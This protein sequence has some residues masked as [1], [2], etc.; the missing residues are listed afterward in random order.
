M[1]ILCLC[2]E[3]YHWKLIPGY[4]SAFRRRNIQ[5]FCIDDTL[6][7]DIHIDKILKLC[8]EQPSWI[9][10]FESALPLLPLGLEHSSIPTVCFHP[11]TYAFTKKRIRWSALFDHVAVFH[12]GYVEIFAA[13]GHPGAFL[14]PHAVNKE[15]FDGPEL[16]REFEVGW[17]GQTTGTNYK[18]RAALLPEL[19]ARFRMNDFS[20]HYSLEEV[21]GVYKRSRIT[22]NI[23]RDD[24]PQDANL[25]VF[26]ALASGALL[27]TQLPTELSELGFK[28]GVGYR[29]RSEIL[30]LVENYLR[31]EPARTKIGS[32]ARA[33][34]LSEHTYDS[35][36]DQLLSHL[37]NAGPGNLAPT[38]SWPATKVSLVSLDFFASHL[39]LGAALRR[40]A[41]I[42]G[43]DLPATWEGAILLARASAKKVIRFS[44]DQ[45][46]KL[47]IKRRGSA[48]R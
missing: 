9:F 40:Y 25:R 29:T 47:S 30:T 20:R 31:D 1:L 33:K 43:R 18:A 4:A 32:A 27:L 41:S 8:P 12:P 46:A 16:P 45:A 5:F 21:A 35:R 24:F 17:V 37:S 42:V 36:V 34:V 19:A 22:V 23:G 28:D 38:R 2:P 3:S 10:H 44:R 7:F 6:P 15:F 13:A 48:S 39:V 11:D 26:E 14:L